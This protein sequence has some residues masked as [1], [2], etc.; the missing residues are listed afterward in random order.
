[1]PQVDYR[2]L[3]LLTVQPLTTK[4]LKTFLNT[5]KGVKD[6]MAWMRAVIENTMKSGERGL[7][8][9][10][11]DLVVHGNVPQ[12]QHPWGKGWDL[13]GRELFVTWWGDGVGFNKWASAKT[14]F[15][16]DQFYIPRDAV[17][18]VA[19]GYRE[20]TAEEGPSS[21]MLGLTSPQDD[22]DALWRGHL[23]RWD[24]Q[25]GLRGNGRN[26][27]P[28]G[29][30]GEQ[31]LVW[32]AGPEIL[33]EHWRELFPGAEPPRPA[34]PIVLPGYSAPKLRYP[35]RF[36]ALMTDPGTPAA[37]TVKEAARVTEMPQRALTRD[38]LPL[39]RVQ[40]V[41]AQYGWQYTVGSGRASGSLFR[42]A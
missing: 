26:M 39:P 16:F 8:V 29:H 38:V 22:V 2:N 21:E 30:C 28:E 36:L 32:A 42:A 18:A 19:N 27:T 9:C 15:L 1:M 25:M 20:A 4:R 3:K 24:L 6:Y 10:R 23:M 5:P 7:V 12:E 31:T 34:E 33:Q 35:E 40:R 37:I 13:D 17:I 14:V 41:L 11:K